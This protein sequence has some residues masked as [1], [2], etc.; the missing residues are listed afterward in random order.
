MKVIFKSW[1]CNAVGAYY[2]NGRKAIG[3]FDID[4]HEPIAT[5]SVNIIKAMCPDNCIHVKNYAEN[6]GM[7]DALIQAGIIE[8][9]LIN[10]T[11]SGYVTIGLYRLTTKALVELWKEED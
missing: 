10:A 6:E 8:D 2:S 4:D 1:N 3:L 9:V 7:T 11:K 5:A